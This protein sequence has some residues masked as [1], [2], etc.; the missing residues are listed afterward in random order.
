M[1]L[2]SLND[3]ISKNRCV[4]NRPDVCDFAVMNICWKSLARF[5]TIPQLQK[6]LMHP[7]RLSG[8][9]CGFIGVVLNFLCETIQTSVNQ[10]LQMSHAKPVDTAAFTRVGKISRFYML[11][12]CAL[13]RAYPD[14]VNYPVYAH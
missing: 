4:L 12:L 9:Q 10:L 6:H 13:I 3:V 5:S 2:F 14:W 8:Q 11:H 7:S 1:S